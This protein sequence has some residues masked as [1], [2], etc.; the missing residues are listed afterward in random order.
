M[1]NNLKSKKKFFCPNI[2]K[3]RFNLFFKL[4]FIIPKI[5][6][7]TLSKLA[8]VISRLSSVPRTYIFNK[9]YKLF[10][11]IYAN[12]LY[13]F[14][15]KVSINKG[16]IKLN[17]VTYKVKGTFLYLQ[18]NKGTKT[19]LTFLKFD[20]LSL[21]QQFQNYDI[22]TLDNHNL[23]DFNL[24]KSFFLKN[25]KVKLYLSQL[26]RSKNTNNFS[27]NFAYKSIIV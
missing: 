27:Y 10:Y 17:S 1:F 7:K 18:L 20:D 13:K 9:I 16:K 3:S 5:K 22:V 23:Q 4:L 8:S 21:E 12:Y 24:Y 19:G 11:K 6:I 2:N 14:C 26:T 15:K 25:N